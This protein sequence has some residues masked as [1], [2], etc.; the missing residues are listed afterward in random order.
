MSRWLAIGQKPGPDDGPIKLPPGIAGAMS[1]LQ[2]A[3][4]K[5][6]NVLSRRWTV[7]HAS[8]GSRS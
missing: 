5:A 1:K 7:R 6:A 8:T 3:K 2:N 4:E